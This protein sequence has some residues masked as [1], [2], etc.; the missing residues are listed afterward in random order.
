[1]VDVGQANVVEERE[2]KKERGRKLCDLEVLF[3][4]CGE[5]GRV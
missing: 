4:L 1:M 3:C 5:G 2:R